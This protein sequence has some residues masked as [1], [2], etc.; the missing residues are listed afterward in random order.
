[1][2]PIVSFTETVYSDPLP[3]TSA[4]IRCRQT[5]MRNR[6]FRHTASR[7]RPVA[8]S[9]QP[10]TYRIRQAPV[11]PLWHG[12]LRLAAQRT[13]QRNS[14]NAGS[15]RA[16]SPRHSHSMAST[17]WSRT[18]SPRWIRRQDAAWFPSQKCSV[19][20][21]GA[22]IVGSVSARPSSSSRTPPRLCARVGTRCSR[23]GQLTT[24]SSHAAGRLTSSPHVRGSS[25]HA[26]ARRAARRRA[27]A[28]RAAPGSVRRHVVIRRDGRGSRRGGL[29]R[30]AAWT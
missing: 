30:G 1:M 12:L 10:V 20:V 23:T 8:T 11:Q 28:M 7:T 17:K 19:A 14:S 18:A 13:V 5:W 9:A 26:R 3:P 2:V 6:Q 16:A 22:Q 29:P 15:C 21:A 24:L 27:R 25:L 4:R